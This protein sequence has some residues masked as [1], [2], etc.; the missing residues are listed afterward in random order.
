M[1]SPQ[2]LA[3]TLKALSVPFGREVSRELLEVYR[4]ALDDLTDTELQT[5][6]AKAIRH[7]RFFP[8]PAELRALAGRG[9]EKA[10]KA[11][12]AEAWGR[13]QEALDA[14]QE[15]DGVDFGLI[16]NAVV[17]NMGGWARMWNE[18]FRAL[19]FVRKKFEE[20]YEA[21][22]ENPPSAMRSAA[23]PPRAGGRLVR[24]LPPGTPP[25]AL[26]QQLGDAVSA[27]VRR[28]ADMKDANKGDSNGK[29]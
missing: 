23:L 1:A 5:A 21:F 17:R 24:Y 10:L 12:A 27:E 22:A 15:D 9:G 20:L 29:D 26:P 25:T 7:C 11:E 14:L 6:A 3:V 13:V 28:L 2:T 18:P 8:P 19:P 16:A 4:V